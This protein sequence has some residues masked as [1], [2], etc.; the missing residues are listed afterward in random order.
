MVDAGNE[1][2]EFERGTVNETARTVI[3]LNRDLMFGSRIANAVRSLGLTPRFVKTGDAL[4]EAVESEGSRAALVILD[5]NTAIDW[6]MVADLTSDPATPPVLGF[7][8]HVDIDGRRAAQAAGVKRIVSNGDFHRD[9]V[10][11]I[12]RYLVPSAPDQ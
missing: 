1:Q 11:L 10:S 4:L 9:T 6:Q 5:M 7:G 8:P 3:V 2:G 12:A